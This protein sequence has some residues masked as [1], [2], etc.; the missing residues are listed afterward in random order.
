MAPSAA[1]GPAPA[2]SWRRRARGARRRLRRLVLRRRRLLAAMLVAGAAGL[3][4]RVVTPAPAPTAQ[5]LV[6][7]R[8]L[9]AGAVLTGADVTVADYP[10]ATV[11]DGLL[12]EP[13]GRTLAGP[14]RRGEPVTDRR[15]VGAALT[16]GYPGLV[17]MPVRIPDA[18]SVALL[19]V[20]DRI[21][22][23]SAGPRTGTARVLVSDAAVLAL[24]GQADRSLP[25]RLVLVA[26]A[27]EAVTALSEAAARGFLSL[28]ISG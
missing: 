7:A 12:G 4:L 9:P 8:D 24:P 25:G 16:A 15:V 5:V 28:T 23:V 11:P 14:M 13:V 10:T 1:S 6:A 18:A 2:D 3:A 17:A 20:G 22:L 26:V 21:S 19:Q 27:P